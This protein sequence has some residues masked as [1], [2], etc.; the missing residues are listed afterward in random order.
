[1]GLVSG[2]NSQ[3]SNHQH[4]VKM[5]GADVGE[6]TSRSIM[7]ISLVIIALA[8]FGGILIYLESVL[9]PFFLAILVYY[10]LIP[11]VDL[12]TQEPK[13][14][15]KC[16]EYRNKVSE[17]TIYAADKLYI[18]VEQPYST[19]FKFFRSTIYFFALGKFPRWLAVLV[20]VLFALFGIGLVFYIAV[21]AVASIAKDLDK[22]INRFIEILGSIV[23]YVR[24]FGV[25]VTVEDILKKI[26]SIDFNSL[27]LS[28][29]NVC[30]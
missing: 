7:V 19:G 24:S 3:R 21:T 16:T 13:A 28:A 2:F 20:A 23:E 5:I 18:E 15:C 30:L 12:L 25:N 11:I 27:A 4:Q 26:E 8:A 1:M 14:H 6:D 22:Y 9:V 29:L 10:L 17:W